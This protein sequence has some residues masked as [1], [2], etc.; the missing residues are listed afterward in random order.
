M[1]FVVVV[2]LFGGCGRDHLD[3]TQIGRFRPVPAVNVILDSLGIADEASPTYAGAEDPRPADLIV[4]ESDYVFGSGDTV[5]VIIY[6]LLQENANYVNDFQVNE[7]GNISVPEIGHIH[8]A[9]LTELELEDEISE[10]LSP[11]LLKNPSVT[12]T[13]QQSESRVFSILGDGVARSNRYGIPRYNFRLMDALAVAGSVRQFNVSYIY[14]ARQ[15][16]SEEPA[17][18]TAMPQRRQTEPGQGDTTPKLR[19]IAPPVRGVTEPKRLEEDEMMEILAPYVKSKNRQKPGQVMIKKR[20][21][22][23]SAVN[24][25]SQPI[26]Q[27]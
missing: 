26:K 24:K 1:F 27:Q 25:Q 8:A 14:I 22:G 11:T 23:Q 9:G 2:V 3:P 7:S 20:P 18:E 12:I 13:L 4:H 16:T 21:T 10:I 19:P 15:V 17:S 6:E 5:R